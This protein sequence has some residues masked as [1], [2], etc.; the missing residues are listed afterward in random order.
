MIIASMISLF[1]RLLFLSFLYR[2]M[3]ITNSA[4][5]NVDIVNI[6]ALAARM[7]VS[8]LSSSRFSSVLAMVLGVVAVDDDISVVDTVVDSISVVDTM[9]GQH[10]RTPHASLIIWNSTL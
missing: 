7:F 6:T 8:L 10:P 3:I 2:V 5:T 9:I 1:T 4:S